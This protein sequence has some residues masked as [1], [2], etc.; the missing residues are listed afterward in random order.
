MFCLPGIGLWVHWDEFTLHTVWGWALWMS[1]HCVVHLDGSRIL[2]TL[3]ET[4]KMMQRKRLE[5]CTRSFRGAQWT[6]T[7]MNIYLSWAECSR[8]ARHC[9]G[10]FVWIISLKLLTNLLPFLLLLTAF[11]RWGL[12][13]SSKFPKIPRMRAT[14]AHCCIPSRHIYEK[15]VFMWTPEFLSLFP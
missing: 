13:S 7:I 10:H 8:H 1:V 3:S 11:P 14:P 9:F 15:N 5:L 6:F 4:V 2:S 12:E